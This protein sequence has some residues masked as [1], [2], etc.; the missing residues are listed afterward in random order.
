MCK[1]VCVNLIYNNKIEFI[2][3]IIASYK[4]NKQYIIYNI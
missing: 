2:N 3:L 4:N 1:C